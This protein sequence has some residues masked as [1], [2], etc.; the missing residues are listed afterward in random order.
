MLILIRTYI[1]KLKTQEQKNKIEV[2]TSIFDNVTTKL[3]QYAEYI[4]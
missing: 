2:F 3:K 1:E 4:S